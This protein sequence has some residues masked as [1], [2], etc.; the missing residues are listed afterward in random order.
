MATTGNVVPLIRVLMSFIFIE[1][2]SK[3][4]S[5]KATYH[6]GGSCS[7][8]GKGTDPPAPSFLI[9]FLSILTIR[10]IIFSVNDFS[11]HI[12]FPNCDKIRYYRRRLFLLVITSNQISLGEI[13][14][15][16]V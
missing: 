14:Y 3:S 1:F 16:F 8:Q 2:A 13:P 5:M 4:T 6:R 10:I 12:Q 11:Y 15:Y 9:I 7:Q